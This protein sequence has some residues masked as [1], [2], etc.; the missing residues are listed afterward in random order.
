[1]LDQLTDTYDQHRSGT[2]SRRESTEADMG[3]LE[4]GDPG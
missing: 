4:T 1:M 2:C 3:V